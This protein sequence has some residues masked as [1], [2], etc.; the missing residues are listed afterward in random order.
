EWYLRAASLGHPEAK[1][2]MSSIDEFELDAPPSYL[3][4]IEDKLNQSDSQD[5]VNIL[6]YLDS[7]EQL[8]NSKVT[9]WMLGE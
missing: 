9:F 7:E 6:K 5:H 1:S 8:D 2:A 4:A 3:K